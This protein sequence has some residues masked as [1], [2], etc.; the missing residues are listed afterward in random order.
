MAVIALFFEI[1]VPKFEATFFIITMIVLTT[2]LEEVRLELRELKDEIHN[3]H[4][5]M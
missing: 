4:R 5:G 3:R 2:A 1:S